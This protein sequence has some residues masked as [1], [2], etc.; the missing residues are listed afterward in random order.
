[1]PSRLSFKDGAVVVSLQKSVESITLRIVGVDGSGLAVL[2]NVALPSNVTILKS[3]CSA[4]GFL[5]ILTPAGEWYCF[6]I[7][8]GE[9]STFTV[10][11]VSTPVTLR[12]LSFSSEATHSFSGEISI[13]S[14]GS[15]H[16]LLAGV[17]SATPPELVFLLWDL[18]YSVVLAS[19]TL[20]IPSTITRTKKQGIR[21]Q[22]SGSTG[23]PQQAILI[24]SPASAPA[25][26]NGDSGLHSM[27]DDSAQRSSVLAIPLAVPASSSVA[28]ALGKTSAT[29]KWTVH[30]ATN[31][32][33]ANLSS[34]NLEAAQVKLLRAMR[35]AMEQKRVEAAD[36]L[37]FDWVAQQETG[38]TSASRA[39]AKPILGY[40]FVKQVLEILLRTP[41]NATTDIPYSPKVMRHLMQQRCVSA[42]MIEGGLFAALRLRNDWESMMLALKTVIDV[43][44]SD[45]AVLLQSSAAAARR[46]Q[47]DENAM[48]VDA[49]AD[50]SVPALSSVLALCTTYTMSAPALRLAIRQHL[51]DAAELTAVLQVLHQWI[52]TWC[53]EDVAL[54][55]ERT[56]KDLHGA[57]VPVLEQKQKGTLPPLDKVL[58]FLQTLLDSSFLTFLTYPPS[59]P[60]L[61]DIFSHL[62][63]ELDFTDDVEQ[64]RGP[65]E[66]FVRAHSKAVH[67]AAHGVQK[68]DLKIDWRKRRK[69]AH[70]Q[71]GMAVGVYQIEE[72]VL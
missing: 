11:S 59:H 38:K 49:A 65:L 21:L 32:S 64:L 43:P 6:Q 13:L 10:A 25:I 72:L 60:I 27:T 3:T 71:A 16:V 41:K 42:G 30:A 31:V 4:A 52:N 20:P 9:T 45:V 14:L 24:L 19:R 8:Y 15:S 36:E 63:P 68:P 69:D 34:T 57:L 46:T 17:S 70:E 39:S 47:S 33:Q 28:N 48:Q 62:E 54:L 2:G 61:R 12:N 44:E 22:L 1:M 29:E 50:S 66:P 37:F 40:Q 55:P 23:G 5:S 53:A 58:A 26:A 35:T 67:E 56:K 51:S 18:Q 7:E